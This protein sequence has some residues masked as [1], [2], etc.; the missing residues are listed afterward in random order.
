[1][2]LFVV[3]CIPGEKLKSLLKTKNFSRN[4]KRM[5]KDQR[6]KYGKWF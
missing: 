6:S 1:M 3:N 2:K 4:S 5:L